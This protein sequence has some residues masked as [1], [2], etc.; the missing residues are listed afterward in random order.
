MSI[1]LCFVDTETINVDRSACG[2]FQ[3]AAVLIECDDD[4]ALKVLE[5]INLTMCPDQSEE[6]DPNALEHVHVTGSEIADYDPSAKVFPQFIEFLSSHIDRFNKNDKA[7][8][9]AYNAS[10]DSNKL[11]NWFSQNSD[12]YYGSWFWANTICVMEMASYALRYDRTKFPNFQLST[13]CKALNIK[14][15]KAHDAMEDVV[16]TIELYQRLDSVLQP[17]ENE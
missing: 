17:G 15:E 9:V 2:I 8:L 13:V 16:A 11:R 6:L 1:K 10:F 14:L 5:K 12:K 4:G 3:L 7:F